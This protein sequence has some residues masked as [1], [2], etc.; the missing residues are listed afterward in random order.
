MGYLEIVSKMRCKILW[1]KIFFFRFRMR[2]RMGDGELV[3]WSW[4]IG[5]LVRE[6]G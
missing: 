2:M 5:E 3:L 4:R 1:Y 6:M